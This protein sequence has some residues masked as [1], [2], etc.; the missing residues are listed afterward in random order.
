MG[1]AGY[2]EQAKNQSK[3]KNRTTEEVHKEQ[4]IAA[5]VHEPHLLHYA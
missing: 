1:V 3:I 2:E 4:E 5:R